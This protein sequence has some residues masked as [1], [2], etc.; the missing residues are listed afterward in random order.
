VFNHKVRTADTTIPEYSGLF[1]SA[2]ELNI[3]MVTAH[4]G[5][6]TAREKS[7]GTEEESDQEIEK[8]QEARGYQATHSTRPAG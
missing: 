1:T 5:N 8:G 6:L 2:W 7:D 4:G 3:S